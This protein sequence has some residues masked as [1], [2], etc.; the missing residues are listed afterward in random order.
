MEIKIYPINE[1]MAGLIPAALESELAALTEDIRERAGRLGDNNAL[2]LPIVL[3]RGEIIDGRSRQEACKR[4]GIE[5]KTISIDWNLTEEE[6]AAE[7]IS[8]NKRR[9]LTAT[10]KAMVALKH[11][12]KAGRSISTKDMSI[13]WG[14]GEQTLK[15]AIYISKNRPEL[16]NPL[17]GGKSIEITDKK[18]AK[19][20]TMSVNSICEYVKR[21]KE[22]FTVVE[23]VL[24][25]WKYDGK[26]ST[27]LGKDWYY[28]KV[29][30]LDI[31]DDRIKMLISE[32]AEYK[33]DKGGK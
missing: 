10:Q 8:L 12:I 18:G 3:W 16:I 22:M 13:K 6:V 19:T 1:D 17:H 31:S 21:T 30:D 7:V 20:T 33:F 24:H 28:D 14:I 26:I 2:I 9:N 25:E 5:T 4:L 32:L 11:K 23:T 15:N 29:K 27:Q